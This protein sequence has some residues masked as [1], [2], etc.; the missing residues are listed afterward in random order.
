MRGTPPG[1]S[2][3]CALSCR[4]VRRKPSK[5]TG[6][7]IS[8]LFTLFVVPSIYVLIAKRRTAIANASHD[9]PQV[10]SV[11]TNGALIAKPV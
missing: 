11:S 7:T 4:K 6:M 9:H 8:T 10:G 2:R 5:L 1:W 3:D